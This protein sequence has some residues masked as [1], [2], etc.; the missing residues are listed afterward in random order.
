M[1]Q[2]PNRSRPARR[3]G[4]PDLRGSVVRAEHMDPSAPQFVPTQ[5]KHNGNES[6]SS[7]STKDTDDRPPSEWLTRAE[8]T[9]WFESRIAD[10]VAT[11]GATTQISLNVRENLSEE[12]QRFA[13]EWKE[14]ENVVEYNENDRLKNRIRHLERELNRANHDH[15]SR[16]KELERTIA[17]QKEEL[18]IK[19]NQLNGKRLLWLASHPPSAHQKALDTYNSTLPGGEL[20]SNMTSAQGLQNAATANR[21][22]NLPPTSLSRL[23]RASLAAME[24]AVQDEQSTGGLLRRFESSKALPTGSALP[25]GRSNYRDHHHM[26]TQPATEINFPASNMAVVPFQTPAPPP[27]D[28]GADYTAEFTRIF[29]II[30]GWSREYAHMVNPSQDRGIAS[31]NQGLWTYMMRLTYPDPQSAHSHVMAL[32]SNEQTRFWFVMRMAMTYCF[33]EIMHPKTFQQFNVAVSSKLKSI[34][35]RLDAKPVPSIDARQELIR[36]QSNVVEQVIASPHYTEF[37]NAA[38]MHHTKHLRDMLGPLLNK[39]CSRSK[40]GADLGV[41]VIACFD[42]GSK[43]WSARLSFQIIFPELLGA[44]FVAGTMIAKDHPNDNPFHLQTKQK[45]L[46]LVMTPSITMR[47]DNSLTIIAKNLH[48]ANVLLMT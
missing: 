48:K 41:L 31:G 15:I 47:D 37:R 17:L 5:L 6:I 33:E 46:K 9:T 18:D 42:L 29:T 13:S 34:K 12:L 26:A 25:S 1:S 44:K 11:V 21:R 14:R 38:L 2:L 39:N 10:I 19:E 45:R 35:D 16:T 43:M 22:L 32:L 23:S 7:D 28:L 3:P 40:A 30:E 36:E 8:M 20:G 4:D 24:G 27:P